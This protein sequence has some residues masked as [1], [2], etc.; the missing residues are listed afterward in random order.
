MCCQECSVEWLQ[1]GKK[2][3]FQK[4]AK[5]RLDV[6]A[7]CDKVMKFH[8]ILDP[9]LARSIKAKNFRSRD[10]KREHDEKTPHNAKNLR[11]CGQKS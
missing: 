10:Q 8:Q 7:D 5:Q 4:F 2:T 1:L 11:S 9:S 6:H 3:R